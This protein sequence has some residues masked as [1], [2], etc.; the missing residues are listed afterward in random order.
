MLDIALNNYGPSKEP[1]GYI[2]YVRMG[3]IE[4]DPML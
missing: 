2:D 3:A 1:V 4:D